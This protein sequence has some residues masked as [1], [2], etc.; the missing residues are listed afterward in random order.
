MSVLGCQQA[1]RLQVVCLHGQSSLPAWTLSFLLSSKGTNGIPGNQEVF[2]RP[3]FFS[4]FQLLPK[5]P[6][7]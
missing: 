4:L 2:C 5:S 1:R 6:K 7:V 3:L